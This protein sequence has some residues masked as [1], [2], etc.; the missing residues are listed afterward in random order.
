[1]NGVL[2]VFSAFSNGMTENASY[3]AGTNIDVADVLTANFI[4][5]VLATVQ[6][7][8]QGMKI[9]IDGT[10]TWP[11]YSFT[12]GQGT[13]HTLVAESPQTDSNGRVWQFANWS[14]NGAQSHSVTMPGNTTSYY[15]TANY[16]EQDQVT[17][18]SSPN[19]LTFTIDG[20][21]CTTPCVV[22]KAAGS[23]SQVVAPTSIPFSGGSEYNFQ[24]W[25]D[26]NTS[27]SRTVSYSQN[28]LTLT[29]SYQTLYQITAVANP[30]SSATFTMNPASTIGY[31]AIG[32]QVQITAVP[33]SGYKFV[34]WEGGLSGTSASGTVTMNSPQAVQADMQSAPTITPAGIESATGPT[35]DGSVAA[36]SLISIYGSNLSTVTQVGPSNPLAQTL[37]SVT[38]TVGNSILPLLFVSPNQISAQVPWELTPGSYTLT[39][40]QTGQPSVPGTFTVSRDAPGI[41]TQANAQNLPLAVALHQDGT[42]VTFQSPVIQGEQITI[43]G[44]GFGPYNPPATDGFAT[45]APNDPLT[46]PAVVTIGSAQL[47]PDFAGS[48]PGLV[49]VAIVKVTIVAGT[50][51]ATNA[52]LTIT[53]G[54]KPSSQVV[55]PMQ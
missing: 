51:T 11:S 20:N 48:E 1:L 17:I 40:E 13:T 27:P 39:I 35:P 55:L 21:T 41:F 38:V 14:D 8:P 22:N 15:V 53:V 25:S 37:G 33:A 4:A 47:Q 46:V 10:D 29:A 42:L 52:N 49:G 34:K 50:P 43:Y 9:M 26:G 54:G 45:S 6:T 44:T 7:N 18:N 30:A 12:W 36:G 5:G 2:W 32:T 23:T 3:T 16:T 31:Y 28:T 24:S 19:G